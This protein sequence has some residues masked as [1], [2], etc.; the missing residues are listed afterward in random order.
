MNE[1]SPPTLK[2]L[3]VFL[4]VFGTGF[5]YILW[6]EVNVEPYFS[7]NRFLDNTVSVLILSAALSVTMVEG[8]TMFAEVWIE[9]R[10]KRIR[11]EQLEADAQRLA[12]F[13]GKDQTLTKDDD[14][15]RLRRILSTG[16]D[17]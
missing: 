12:T 15:S 6:Y 4:I 11:E 1:F 17:T 2:H 13:L 10:R 14:L 7:L 5:G 16:E 3:C 8:A 9:K